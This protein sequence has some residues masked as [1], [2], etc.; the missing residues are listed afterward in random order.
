[1]YTQGQ[2]QQNTKANSPT[3]LLPT[4]LFCQRPFADL[5]EAK[6][7]SHQEH[8]TPD[9]KTQPDTASHFGHNFSQLRVQNNTPA[10]IQPKLGIENADSSDEREN[11]SPEEALA[12]PLPSSSG[13]P[14][15]PWVK[16]KMEA[17]FA[18][19]FSDVQIYE[20]PEAKALGAIAYAQGSHI[21]FAPGQYDPT[22]QSGQTILGHE[23]AHVV[24]Q[25]AGRVAV[26]QGKGAPINADPALEKEADEQGVKAARGE[27][28]NV[29]DASSDLQNYK[30]HAAPVQRWLWPWSDSNDDKESNNSLAEAVFGRAGAAGRENFVR[31]QEGQAYKAGQNAPQID[32]NGTLHRTLPTSRWE[33]YV[34]HLFSDKGG[35]RYNDPG[36]RLIYGSPS[37]AESIGEMHAYGSMAD[38]T[39]VEF[40]YNA[41]VDPVTGRGGVADISNNLE[42]LGLTA[43]A[44]T[45]RKG[46]SGSDFWHKLTGE[47]PYLHSRAV[48][49]GALDAGASA[50]HAPSATGGNQI[51]IIPL[52]T[53]P[54]QLQYQQHTAYDA[55]ANPLPTVID[56]AHVN[57][58]AGTGKG[59]MPLG[60]APSPHGQDPNTSSGRTQRGGSARYGALAAGG[61]SAI[62][63]LMDGDLSAADVGDI[64]LNTGIGALSGVANDALHP[65]MG[66]G[67]RGGLKAGG[68]VDAVT[69]GLFS[70][71]DN[72]GAYQ[73]GDVSAGQATA[74]V[75]VDTSVGIGSGLAGAAAG[76]AIGSVIPVAGTA[77]GA[78]LGFLAGTAGSWLAHKLADASGFTDSVVF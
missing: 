48:G 25:R 31:A 71:W 5:A 6:D 43:E 34:N 62:R 58:H 24:Q 61:M 53:D 30:G 12:L 52:N 41:T 29:A 55:N 77:V 11:Q 67:F 15:P 78:G 27:A 22:S 28:A 38:Q 74:N 68:V 37:A 39:R 64:G 60:N 51:D 73:R 44:L 8:E 50:L 13:S 9:L 18:T 2:T 47:D 76:A 21:H 19:D 59:V 20:G 35:G 56:P 54:T 65:R 23:L 72:A 14:L 1:M 57:Q 42:K 46:K 26:P 32:Y 16:Q 63:N 36:M 3:T 17:A 7:V 40:N 75:V 33:G 70:T 49:K 45:A 10:V 66:G 4:G 69:S